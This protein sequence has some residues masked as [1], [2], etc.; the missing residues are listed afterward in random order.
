MYEINGFIIFNTE[1]ST[2]ILQNELGIVQVDNRRMIEFLCFLDT[3]TSKFLVSNVDLNKWFGSELEN[4]L[5]F[6][7]TNGILKLELSN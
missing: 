3:K 6:L 4:A 7:L 1:D 2:I 5:T